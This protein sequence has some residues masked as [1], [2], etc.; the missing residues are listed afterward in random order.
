MIDVTVA[1]DL[2]F[3]AALFGVV[4]FVWTGWAQERPPSTL[5]RVVLAVLGLAGCA[6]AG[7]SIPRLIR[8]WG[9][10]TAI[11]FG[12]AAW[13]IYIVV[14]VLEVVA[15]VVGA[16]VLARTRR[17]EF[18]APF[19]LLVVGVH[20]FPL[21]F[22][23]GQPIILATAVLITAAAVAAALL[24]REHCAPSFWCGILAG[25]IFLVVGTICALSV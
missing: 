22:V 25:P 13:T 1:R 24:P 2:V 7:V 10:P 4:T 5:W 15:L 18:I 21:A 16:I 17:S 23:F 8:A 9:E 14:C 12:S 11:E 20:F 19:A 6:L 3:T